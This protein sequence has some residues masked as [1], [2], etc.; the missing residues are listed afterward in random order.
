MIKIP[1]KGSV[2]KWNRENRKK[3]RLFILEVKEEDFSDG[4]GKEPLQ[5]GSPL[6]TRVKLGANPISPI[7]F[8]EVAIWTCWQRGS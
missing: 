4:E 1:P 7:S 3:P 6:G 5:K 2:R 8:L